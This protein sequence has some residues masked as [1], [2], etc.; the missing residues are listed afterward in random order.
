MQDHNI[1]MLA[2]DYALSISLN[3]PL[4]SE[5]VSFDAAKIQQFFDMTK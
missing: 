5:R 4:H 1:Q 3:G 2:L